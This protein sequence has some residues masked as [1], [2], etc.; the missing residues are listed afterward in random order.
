M[1]K[2]LPERFWGRVLKSD[3]G[4]WEYSGSL[5]HNGY[6]DLSVSYG[7]R[8]AHRYSWALSNGAIPNDKMVLHSCDNRKCVNPD[9]LFLG[10]GKDNTRDMYEKGRQR[11]TGAKNPLRGENAPQ[12]KISED[13]A[14]QIRNR[15][16]PF[17]KGLT[18]S[19]SKEF[20]I[21]TQEILDIATGRKWSHMKE[22]VN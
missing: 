16:K 12:A 8:R 19:L 10:E 9:H 17:E 13:Q 18:L 14:I 22:K 21:C 3:K 15:Y 7:E 11:N 6:G 2:T 1:R 5:T 4:C 20:G